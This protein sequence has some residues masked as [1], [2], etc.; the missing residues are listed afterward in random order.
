MHQDVVAFRTAD[1]ATLRGWLGTR[2]RDA[3]GEATATR[4]QLALAMAEDSRALAVL[5]GTGVK[6]LGP[7]AL[8]GFTTAAL[9]GARQ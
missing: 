5:A 2:Q 7:R 6:V 4:Q 1:G 9:S 8:A 3:V